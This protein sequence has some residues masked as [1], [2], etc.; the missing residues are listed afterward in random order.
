LSGAPERTSAA[1]GPEPR[2]TEQSLSGEQS[3]SPDPPRV[4]RPP[5]VGRSLLIG[6]VIAAALAAVLF[7][8]LGRSSSGSDAGA[9]VSVGSQAPGFTLPSLTGGPAVNLDALGPDLHR[10]VVLNFFASWCVPCQKETP[11]LARTAAEI[12]AKNSDIQFVGVDVADQP[13]NAIPFVERSGITYPVGNDAD[14]RVT[15]GLYGLNGEPNTFFIAP[16]GEVLGHVIGAV[17]PS[18]LTGWIHRLT[19]STA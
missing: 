10:P 14:L 7:L 3:P 5:R 6:C 18:E 16:D 12:R 8:G 17:T 19:N 11:L 9:V 1:V 4:R 13:S 15:S 2:S